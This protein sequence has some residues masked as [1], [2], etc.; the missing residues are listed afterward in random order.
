M[1]EVVPSRTLRTLSSAAILLHAVVANA[2]GPTTEF[3]VTGGVRNPSTQ[4]LATLQAATPIEQTDLFQAGSTPQTHTYIGA[5]LWGTLDNAGIIVDPSVDNDILDKY[6]VAT[7]SD[8]YRVVLSLGELNPNFGAR[9]DLLAYAERVGGNVA[10]LTADGVARITAPGDPKG[11]RYLSNLANLD[12]RSTKPTQGSVGGGATTRFAVS[13]NVASSTSF[14]LAAL[15]A[16]TPTTQSVGGIAYTG[17][18][19]WSLLTSAVGVPSNGAVK[20]DL[21]GKYVVATGS[22]GY[23]VVFSLGELDPSFGGQP[24]FVAYLADGVPLAP[25]TGFARIVVPNDVRRGRWVSN[26]I[27]LEVF[28]VPEP[29]TTTLLF[30]GLAIAFALGRRQRGG[31]SARPATKL[32]MPALRS[33]MY[34]T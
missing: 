8:G 11:G 17:V 21:L 5:S 26:L 2:A 14:D 23:S 6:V 18:S 1:K 34:G 29:A 24:D 9:P 27:G 16:L 12:V 32:A 33:G 20:N 31:T 7:A 15:E 10:P 30:V 25:A 13:G 19:L 28:S 22:D 3:T 4:T